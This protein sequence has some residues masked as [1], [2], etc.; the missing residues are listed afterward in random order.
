VTHF[1]R[2]KADD[3][4]VDVAEV[5]C[6]VVPVDDTEEVAV[7]DADVVILVDT[8]VLAVLVIDED[9]VEDC[10]VVT[11][12][13]TELVTVDVCELNSQLKK[14][15]AKKAS[16]PLLRLFATSVHPLPEDFV[17][18]VPVPH[19]NPVLSSGNLENSP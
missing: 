19:T 11:V 10:V 5:V 16:I 6:D 4:T 2:P 9:A 17:S 13:D 12:V 7:V 1:I 3:V 18:N 15:P 8:D 14:V